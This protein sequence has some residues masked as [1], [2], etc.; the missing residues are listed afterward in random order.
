[1][2]TQVKAK[3]LGQVL[4]PHGQVKV[5][6][7][8]LLLIGLVAAAFEGIFPSRFD[9]MD[10]PMWGNVLQDA[11][12]NLGL[13]VCFG[14]AIAYLGQ[15]VK[16]QTETVEKRLLG[17]AL[18]KALS[19]TLLSAAMIDAVRIVSFGLLITLFARMSVH[20]GDNPVPITGQTLGVLLTGAALGSR[21]GV[22][23]TV[24]Y[25]AQGSSGMHVF[26]GGG[27]GLFWELASGGYLLGFVLTAFVV[28][29]LVERGW[30]RG[31]RLLVAM[32]IGNILL[33]IPGLIQLSYFVGWDKTFA[34]GLYPFI[35]GDLAKLYIASLSV[36][37]VWAVVNYRHW[38][39]L[40]WK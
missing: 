8:L 3:T 10:S 13:V 24:A 9:L 4:F 6:T 30:D 15:L 39:R 18:D 23:T 7:I 14:L 31:T 25:I 28:G 22:L 36:P 37:T 5:Y 32:L 33:Y 16:A 11:A 2:I 29:F 27:Y 12:K 38:N 20:F 34:Y 19:P 21:L 26:A 40:T 1:L 17:V 35:P